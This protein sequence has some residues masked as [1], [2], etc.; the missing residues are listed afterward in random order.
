[1]GTEGRMAGW[2]TY[3]KKGQAFP[4][5]HGLSYTTF[6][7]TAMAD[8]WYLNLLEPDGKIWRYA[9]KVRNNGTVPGAE[10]AQLYISIP[11]LSAQDVRPKKEFRDA[12]K[13]KVLDPGEEE[14]LVFG[15]SV[16]DISRW[17]TSS[18]SWAEVEDVITSWVGA[19][20]QDLRLS[21]CVR[22]PCP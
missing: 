19:S 6:E 3:E 16:R 9:I 14:V 2:H 18:Q 22:Q 4:F 1:M 11:A 17:N 5:G 20:S 15:L 13:T 7:Y 21:D 8:G 10:T 12:V